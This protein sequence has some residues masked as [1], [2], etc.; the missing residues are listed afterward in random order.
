[1]RIHTD[2][3]LPEVVRLSLGGIGT[4]PFPIYLIFDG[5]H[6][7]ERSHH[8]TPSAGLYWR[9][10]WLSGNILEFRD[11]GLRLVVTVP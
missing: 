3:A 8:T 6:S 10:K 2:E 11:G 5:G 1:M 9:V 7:D 4:R